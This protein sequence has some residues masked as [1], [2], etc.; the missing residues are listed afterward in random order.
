MSENL[1]SLEAE[2]PIK[3]E[4]HFLL[5]QEDMKW[6]QRAKESWLQLGD[7][8]TKYFHACATQ[9]KQRSQILKIKD[10]TGQW[11]YTQ[12]DIEEAFVAYYTEPFTTGNEMDMTDC[13]DALNRKVT[14]EM[15][16]SFWQNSL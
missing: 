1:D 6:R 9:K 14:M 15:N 5:E 8:N 11:C 3:E 16:Q 2:H 13:L 10:T 7:R 4:L 12:E